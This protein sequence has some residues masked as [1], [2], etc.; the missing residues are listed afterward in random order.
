[1][2]NSLT[3]FIGNFQY[4]L[5]VNIKDKIGNTRYVFKIKILQLHLSEDNVGKNL[6]NMSD[7]RC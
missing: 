7:S 5:V 1:M 6:V 3:S 2:P 4:Y